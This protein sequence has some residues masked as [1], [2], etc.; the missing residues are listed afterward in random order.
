MAR[1]T[2][3]NQNPHLELEN[4]DLMNRRTYLD[5][6]NRLSL[7]AKSIFK[8]NGLPDSCNERYLED[9]LFRTGKAIFYYDDEYGFMTLK[10][11]PS[12]HF[13]VYGEP[14]DIVVSGENGFIK[15]IVD[16]D[17]VLIRN[18]EYMLPTFP[19]ISLY[20]YRLY[21]V[22]RAIDVNIKNQKFPLL[23]LCDEKQK[24][25][26]KNLYK[27]IDG[28]SPVIFGNKQ[29]DLENVKVF[30]TEAPYVADKLMDHKHQ[31]WNECMNFL[32]INNANTDKRERLITDEVNSNNELIM[33]NVVTM[34]KTREL[35]CEQIN[36]MFGLN[37]SVELKKIEINDVIN[38]IYQDFTPETQIIEG[39]EQN[40]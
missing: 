22:E 8:W 31:I 21:E 12:N 20:A 33:F 37:I 24:L 26:M 15:N 6:L 27:K 25:T 35:A 19:T 39:G 4:T 17:Y 13:N 30:N 28:N 32:G 10:C 29:I 11:N 2:I 16:Q 18:N 36:S 5:Y 3:D 7:I 9:A 40:G 1:E 34:L 14:T 23:V 38:R